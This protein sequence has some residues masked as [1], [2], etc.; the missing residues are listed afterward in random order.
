MRPFYFKRFFPSILKHI[1]SSEKFNHNQHSDTLTTEVWQN[2]DL[3]F[4]ACAHGMW[5]FAG[6]GLNSWHSSDPSCCSDNAGSLTLCATGEF[7]GH[8]FWGGGLSRAAPVAHG[9]SQARDRIEAAAASLHHSHSNVGTDACLWPT[10]Q[11][12]AMPDPQPTEQGQGSYPCPHGCQ[13][14]LLTTEPWQE[15]HRDHF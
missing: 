15:L 13:V 5:K 3:F 1:K 10:P 6:Q 4:F 8:F 7:W 14:G 2:E 9:G 11:P 12:S